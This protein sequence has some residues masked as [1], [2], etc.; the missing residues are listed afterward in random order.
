MG[1]STRGSERNHEQRNFH[2]YAAGSAA[3]FLVGAYLSLPSGWLALV[4]AMAAI[5]ATIV[6]VRTK[7]LS[8]EFQGLLFLWV[9]AFSSGLLLYIA[10]A[11]AGAVSTTPTGSI[12]IITAAAVVSYAWERRFQADQW[13]HYFLDVLS[14]IL[15]VGA[16][17]TFLVYGLLRLTQ[18]VITPS[19]F[20]CRRHPHTDHLR[21]RPV[22]RL[23]RISMAA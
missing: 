1:S 13:Q 12:L 20:P 2:V 16:T 23:F 11:F 5:A 21:S 10:R 17:A 8:L 18:V 6:G 9:A 3:L 19:G 15:A 14:A 22:T 7:H 4:L